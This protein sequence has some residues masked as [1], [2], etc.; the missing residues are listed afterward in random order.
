M[1][2]LVLM[3]RGNVV[4]FQ[5]RE[6]S[7][8][9]TTLAEAIQLFLGL[10]E[11]KSE[12]TAKNYELFINEFLEYIIGRN[13][14]TATWD[15]LLSITYPKVL[16]F[17]NY[18]MSKTNDKG[19]RVNCNRTINTKIAS[20]KS[21]YKELNKTNRMVDTVVVQLDNLNV[22]EKDSK[23]HGALSIEELENLYSFCLKERSLGNAKKVF[24][25][26][27][28]TIAV[29]KTAILEVKWKDIKQ[30]NEDGINIW[31]IHTLDKG[32]EYDVN[33]I[34]DELYE[35]LITLRKKS[36]TEEDYVFKLNEKTLKRCLERFCKQYDIEE[37]RNISIHSLKKTSMDIVYGRTKD[38]LETARHGHHKGVEMVYKHYQGKNQKLSQK[39]S[40]TMDEKIDSTELENYTK[41]EL[42]R[43]IELSGHFVIN[44]VLMKLK[45]GV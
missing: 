34:S 36:D 25:R 42:I 4:A 44:E 5:P 28:V 26:V 43:A 10:K 14:H 6:V 38:V 23:S 16:K 21:L 24:F 8:D 3:S 33:P 18:L 12:N 7:V 39:P 9:D 27:A 11:E 2:G 13:I 22:N 40:Y 17:R 30:V 35:E 31:T 45:K 41:E 19:E 29:R 20:L 37:G 32:N 15:E 1:K